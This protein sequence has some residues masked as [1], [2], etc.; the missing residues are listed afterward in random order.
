MTNDSF[1]HRYC[2]K[3]HCSPEQFEEHLLRHCL[4]SRSA[5]LANFLLRL[6]PG[7]FQEDLA[8]IREI[9][10]LTNAEEVGLEIRQFRKSH[11]VRGLLSGPL[12]VRVSGQRLVNLADELFGKGVVIQPNNPNQTTRRI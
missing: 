6:T 12:R 2:E 5:T 7:Y 8:L 4:H 11:P 10:D 1:I 9:Q 3:F